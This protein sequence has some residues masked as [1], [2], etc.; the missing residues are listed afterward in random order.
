MSN[1]R[2]GTFGMRFMHGIWGKYVTTRLFLL[3]NVTNWW[4]KLE[5]YLK[6]QWLRGLYL[7]KL[8]KLY[9]NEQEGLQERFLCQEF[10]QN[11]G[12]KTIQ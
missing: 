11:H 12:F 7:L 3:K 9:F 1:E 5:V 2:G 4:V 8:G 6:S 10:C